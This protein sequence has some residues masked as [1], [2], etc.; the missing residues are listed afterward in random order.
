MADT[1]DSSRA[2]LLIDGGSSEGMLVTVDGGLPRS[3]S[4]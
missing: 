1:I 2:G 4:R 3:S